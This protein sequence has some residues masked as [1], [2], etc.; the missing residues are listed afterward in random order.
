MSS[1]S[2]TSQKKREEW[3]HYAL[4]TVGSTEF[5]SL[6]VAA[7]EPRFGELMASIGFDTLVFQ[8][9]RGSWLPTQARLEDD[10]QQ[11]RK[12]PSWPLDRV[13]YRFKED[14]SLD[15]E[16]ASLV[17][18]HAGAATTMESL[19]SK[20]NLIVVANDT[21][22]DNHQFELA[23]EMAKQRYLWHASSPRLLH[24]LVEKTFIKKDTKGGEQTSSSLPRPIEPLTRWPGSPSS[25]NDVFDNYL[26]VNVATE[27]KTLKTLV[28]LGSGGHTGEMFRLIRS[29][30]RECF[31][32]LV[33]CHA[34]SDELSRK[35]V[36]VVALIVVVVQTV[37]T[38]VCL[39]SLKAVAF[40]TS[41]KNN[42]NSKRSKGG[43]DLPSKAEEFLF[44]IPR[45]RKVHQSYFTSIFTTLYALFASFFL[46]L[47][48]RPD[49]IVCNGPGTC[50][51]IVAL[52]VLLNVIMEWNRRDDR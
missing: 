11:P 21:L 26:K 37:E 3:G 30:D 25:S 6:I 32:P 13:Y 47:R 39:H 24:E 45:S 50:V 43:E 49:F 44:A 34:S 48:T 19:L 52:A 10:P 40:E 22:M 15:I 5:D 7:S 16:N 51:P 9:G 14:L 42:K 18:S 29:I 17:I 2:S 1:S 41:K 38:V 8:I 36:R 12:D 4:V 23:E 28:I 27:K 46:L 33:Y 35:K 31:S 20:R